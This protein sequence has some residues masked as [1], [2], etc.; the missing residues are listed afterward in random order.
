MSDDLLKVVVDALQSAPSGTIEKIANS[1]G[2][3][4]TTVSRIKNGV[5]KNPRWETLK[6]IAEYFGKV[7]QSESA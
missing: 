4:R 1:T 6:S 5:T 2:I 7:P 3:P